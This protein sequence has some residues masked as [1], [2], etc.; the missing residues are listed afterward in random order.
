MTDEDE[1]LR[2]ELECAKAAITAV[3]PIDPS[4]RFNVLLFAC[5]EAGRQALEQQLA[6]PGA[7]THEQKR[8]AGAL[9]RMALA[10]EALNLGL[11]VNASAQAGS[12]TSRREWL[13]G[14][15]EPPPEEDPE[16][17]E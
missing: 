10:V 7:W 15:R 4:R 5:L 14:N 9:R 16:R 2:R 6:I 8:Q 1:D 3:D 11:A 12:L 17:P 13:L